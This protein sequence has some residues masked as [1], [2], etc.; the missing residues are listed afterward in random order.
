[1]NV[2]LLVSGGRTAEE[3]NHTNDVNK[4]S[5][6]S[7]TLII[8][9]SWILVVVVVVGTCVIDRTFSPPSEYELYVDIVREGT[10]G[11]V[12]YT[13]PQGFIITFSYSFAL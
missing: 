9:I 8:F 10:L 7:H 3:D 11:I 6:L 13:S 1:M 2:V 5:T 4:S 12:Y